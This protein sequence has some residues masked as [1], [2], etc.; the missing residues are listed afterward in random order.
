LA[1][2]QDSKKLKEWFDQ[3]EQEWRVLRQQLF[4]QRLANKGKYDYL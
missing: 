3:Q 1:T 4:N 2:E